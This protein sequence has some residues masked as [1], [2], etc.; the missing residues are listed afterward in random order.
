M[1]LT[2]FDSHL[3]VW[4]EHQNTPWGRLFYNVA[5]ANLQRH[6][7]PRPLH[8]LDAGGGN[9]PDAIYLATQ[10][11]TIALVDGSSEMLAEARRAAVENNVAERITFYH[12]DV[13]TI[14]TLFPEP[15]FDAALC[16][17]VVQYVDD[18]ASA[19]RAVCAPLRRNALI[20]LICINR[21]SQA[22]REATL[23]LD[24]ASA[25]AALDSTTAISTLFDL[26]MRLFA[27]E[28]LA[29]LLE[30]AGYTVVGQYG[31]RCVNDYISN[32]D[33]KSDPAFFAALERLERAMTDKYPYY[34]LA[35]FF[36]IV[37]QRR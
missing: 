30:S 18:A 8:I 35:R 12:A 2:E 26:P 10:G 1:T 21:Y 17:N 3:R 4:Q 16:H 14:P 34:L 23:Q 31:I 36:H 5:R 28:D 6:L 29:A 9:G 20:S 13:A 11:H 33:I 25:Y 32:N 22:Y 27:V 19:L 37:A 24:P 7:E 15:V